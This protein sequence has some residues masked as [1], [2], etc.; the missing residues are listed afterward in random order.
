MTWPKQ[1]LALHS[2]TVRSGRGIDPARWATIGERLQAMQHS[3]R[4]PFRF[5]PAGRARVTQSGE[6]GGRSVI[7]V[8]APDRLGLLST[9]CRWFADRGLSIEAAAVD[10]VDGRVTDVFLVHGECDVD[11]LAQD[12]SGHTST[13]AAVCAAALAALVRCGRP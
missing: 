11:Q 13:V 5:V 12:L 7:R 2:V 1:D 10:T 8:S 3:S 4:P 9:I 6:G